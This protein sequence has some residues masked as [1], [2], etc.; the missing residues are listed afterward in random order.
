LLTE[1]QKRVIHQPLSSRIFL[2]GAAGTGKTTTAIERLLFLLDNRISGSS[3][4]LMT[5]Q[6]TLAGPYLAA[7]EGHREGTGS[8]VNLV[9]IGGLA[10]R[11]VDLFWP[12]ISSEA[13]FG[14]PNH[15][16]VFLTLETTQYFMARL[17]RPLLD[18][19]YFS[20]ISIDRNRLYS[21]I[22]DN[23]NKAAVVGFP[24]TQV[25][26]RLKTAWIGE[27]AMM[28]IYDDTQH[29]ANLFRNFCLEH[30]LLD[31]SLQVEVFIR[32]LWPLGLCRD[33]L[34][35]KYRHLIVDNVEEDTP[36]T[37]DV[38]S[39]WLDEC[40]SGIVVYDEDAGYRRFLGAN[41][42]TAFQVQKH[43]DQVFEFTE[44]FV[45]SDAVS[46]LAESLGSKIIPDRRKSLRSS[47]VKRGEIACQFELVRFFPSMLDWV[48]QQVEELVHNQ[49]CSPGEIVILSPYLSDALR[50]SLMTRLEGVG[51]PVRSHRPSRSLREEPTVQC[52]IT[53]A[54]LAHPEWL[55]YNPELNPTPFDVAYALIQALDQ[56]DLVRANLLTSIVYRSKGNKPQ[57]SSFNHIKAEQQERISYRIGGKFELLR[58]WIL[59]YQENSLSELDYFFS[60]IF[61]EVLSQPGFG[62]HANYPAG[63]VTANLIES[64]QK[65]RWITEGNLLTSG[66]PLGAEYIELLKD[67][68]IAAQYLRSWEASSEDAVLIAPAYTYLMYNQP[69]DYQIW[70]DPGSRGWFERLYQP[71]TQPFVLNRNWDAT[72]VWSDLDEVETNQISLHHLVTGLLRR[73]R[74]KILIGLSNINEQGFEQRGP[75]LHAFQKV[76][77]D[78]T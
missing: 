76:L 7:L 38:L 16:P 54:I 3:I 17:V 26:E 60:R 13:G 64:I 53:L 27:P 12:Q 63:E 15:P 14:Q 39:E 2:H 49:A 36:I 66:K 19:G 58:N 56:L 40:S 61:G 44:S 22:V 6:R 77:Q 55:K 32:H 28:R 30:N 78:L 47:S 34:I 43:C 20:S 42:E 68:V 73:C 1:H 37:H 5:P 29:C 25:G 72:R 31:F 33:Y 11:M 62:F 41:P 69:V 50:F 65:F 4:L 70:L 21:Q 9:T 52:L 35:S 75:L 71:L 8:Q 59:E 57:L 51:I 10:R 67:G 45:M 24:Y 48:C 74:R 23:L 18:E 46:Q